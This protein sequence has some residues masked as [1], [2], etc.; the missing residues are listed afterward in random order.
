MRSPMRGTRHRRRSPSICSAM[1]SRA[2]SSLHCASSIRST[3]RQPAVRP[4]ISIIMPSAC[5]LNLLK[6]C[7]ESLFARTTYPDF[8]VLL[9]VSSIRFDNAAQRAYL[10]TAQVQSEGAHPRLR[11][12][13][14]QFL[15]AEQLGGEPV[16]R[17]GS[18][19]H[20]R[21]H[22]GRHAGLAGETP[23]AVDA[24]QGRRRRAD[25]VLSGQ[26]DSAC[27]RHSRRRRRRGPWFYSACR[28]DPRAIS[29]ALVWSRT[30]LR[31]RRLHADAAGCFQGA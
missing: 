4:K 26:P 12:S 24:R 8:E 18:L 10:E 1:G 20:E 22:R 5:N 16:Q 6:P 7:M 30:L 23:R 2:R 27:R 3:I 15:L 13:A 29:G 31:H 25:A 19:L 14:V 9:V 17:R 28:R 21:R 11:G